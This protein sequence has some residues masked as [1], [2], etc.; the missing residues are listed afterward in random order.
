MEE[1]VVGLPGSIG[2]L[3]VLPLCRRVRVL[4]ALAAYVEGNL[5]ANGYETLKAQFIRN[6]GQSR[7]NEDVRRAIVARFERIHQ[8]V[9]IQSSPLDGLILAEAALAM[10]A[11]GEIVECGSFFGGSTAKLSVLA[12]VLGTRL[13][14][15]DS[16]EGLPPVP[17]DEAEDRTGRLAWSCI[18]RK[19]ACRAPLE[20]VTENVR[21]YGEIDV[22]TFRKGWFA[23]TLTDANLPSQ[24]ALAYTDVV[25]TSSARSCLTRLWPR[26][27][28]GGV[29]FSR[30][31]ALSKVLAA[32]SD[33]ELWRRELCT[34]R[35]LI[36]GAG[37]GLGD[38]SPCLG[39]MVKGESLPSEYVDTLRLH[40][41]ATL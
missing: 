19:G 14:V 32:M 7:W 41:P 27:T 17:L 11:Q 26:L 24:I 29:Y 21:R 18:W 15:F 38:A 39:F 36:F 23:E 10:A 40:K 31:V 16:F 4:R 13:V 2:R 37:F 12:Q 35:P 9:P 30:D 6:G 8:N 33:P 25:L 3:A 28:T 20:A 5:G 34:E 1:K 22:C